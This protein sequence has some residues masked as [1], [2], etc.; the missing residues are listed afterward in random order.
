LG[1]GTGATGS[2]GTDTSKR[3]TLG[4]V[5]KRGM[6]AKVFPG[7]LIR[8]AGG[9]GMLTAQEKNSYRIAA[10]AADANYHNITLDGT[11]YRVCYLCTGA[12]LLRHPT[13]FMNVAQCYMCNGKGVLK[14]K[15]ANPDHSTAVPA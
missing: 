11:K 14:I 10:V 4:K 2:T 9:A 6:L 5:K 7:F 1:S 8:N 3:A 13:E 12:G 15:D